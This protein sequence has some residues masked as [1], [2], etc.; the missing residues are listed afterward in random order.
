MGV[1]KLSD[2]NRP[3][4]S[5]DDA[6]IPRTN[7]RATNRLPVVEQDYFTKGVS[8]PHLC[9]LPVPHPLMDALLPDRYDDRFY[10]TVDPMNANTNARYKTNV[11][12]RYRSNDKFDA[13]D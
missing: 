9:R 3:S 6:V 11:T 12:M 4:S 2:F 7:C 8:T 10:K 5:R 1:S 13:S